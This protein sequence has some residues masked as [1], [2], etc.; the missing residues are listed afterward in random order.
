M[1]FQPSLVGNCLRSQNPASGPPTG[2]VPFQRPSI[3]KWTLT[4]VRAILSGELTV[5][6]SIVVM[7]TRGWVSQG[8]CHRH[9]VS[10][11]L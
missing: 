2:T 8:I 10:D 11:T 4:I 9:G 1:D 3:R 5:R 7:R 6:I